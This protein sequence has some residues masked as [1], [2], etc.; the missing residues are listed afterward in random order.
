MCFL[1][2]EN[3]ILIVNVL[4]GKPSSIG[5]FYCTNI[6]CTIWAE[7]LIF[8]R[9]YVPVHSSSK[10]ELVRYVNRRRRES[11]QLLG[12]YCEHRSRQISATGSVSFN[13]LKLWAH[14]VIKTWFELASKKCSG[15]RNDQCLVFQ[16]DLVR[17]TLQLWSKASTARTLR[18]AINLSFSCMWSC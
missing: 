2:D 11:K 13:V 7:D 1:L 4:L 14:Y 15:T 16:L 10:T 9:F 12:N 17:M 6:Y 18:L 5:P 8:N 3:K